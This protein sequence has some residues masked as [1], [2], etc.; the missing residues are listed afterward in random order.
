MGLSDIAAGIEVH[1][2]QND[3]GVPT[4]DVTSD[5]LSAR[6]ETHEDALPCTPEAAASVLK[7]YAA[8][9]SVGDCAHEAGI[10][11]MTAAKLLHRCGVAGLSPLGPTARDILRDWL[12]GALS[13]SE[14]IEL[15]G[16][17]EA[18]VALATYVETHD[19]VPELADAVA[20]VL[21]P[22]ANATIEK[23]DALAETMSSVGDLR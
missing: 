14:A 8:G 19:A 21:E 23:R 12:D 3:R 7:S 20:G 5:S 1:E 22:G 17:D 13:R 18:D 10:A 6:L 11:P 15:V 16:A 9:T 4:V 2:R